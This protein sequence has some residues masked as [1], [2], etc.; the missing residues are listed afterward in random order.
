MAWRRRKIAA[1]ALGLAFVLPM[2]QPAPRTYAKGAVTKIFNEKI[3]GITVPQAPAYDPGIWN[4]SSDDRIDKFYAAHQKELGKIVAVEKEKM[5]IWPL[6]QVLYKYDDAQMH[7]RYGLTLA[8]AKEFRQAFADM[9][10]GRQLRNNCYSYAISHPD[11]PP[12]WKLSPGE[13]AGLGIAKEGKFDAKDLTRLVEADGLLSAGQNPVPKQGYYLVAMFVIP[14]DDFHFVRQDNDGTWSHKPGD[15][16]V[17]NLDFDGKPI[18]DPRHAA[19]GQYQFVSYFYV[20]EGGLKF[21][22]PDHPPA[23]AKP[24]HPAPHKP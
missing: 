1:A 13:K 7:R 8:E 19:L 22:H 3:R 18:T 24:R 10:D 12:G 9:T 17:T 11:N 14:Q 4:D 5:Y 6:A 20:P 16:E 21:Q 23:K 2:T 15:E